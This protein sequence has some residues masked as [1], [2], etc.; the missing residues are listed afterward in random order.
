METRTTTFN[1]IDIVRLIETMDAVRE[2][3]SDAGFIFRIE[4]E[5]ISGG[6][7]KSV[8][9]SFYGAGRQ[10]ASREDAFEIHGDQPE[11][12]LG[13]DR[14]PGPLEYILHGL[15]GC[16]GTTFIY[17]ASMHGIR[18]EALQY[19]LEG[20]IDLRGL[21]GNPDVKPEYDTMSVNFRVTSDAPMTKLQDLFLMARKHSPVFNTITHPVHIQA[22][23]EKT[24][25]EENWY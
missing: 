24:N 8:V 9:K 25:S 18:I 1:G 11:V 17:F 12:L 16:L 7:Y 19:S 4:S 5:W 13:E 10:D 15:A 14:A 6:H 2:K 21:F 22:S 3:P 20:R 23:L